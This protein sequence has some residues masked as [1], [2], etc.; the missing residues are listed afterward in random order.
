MS[1]FEDIKQGLSEAIQYEKIHKEG[2][3]QMATTKDMTLH[4]KI[5]KIADMAGVLQKSK[6]GYSYKYV[7]E[8]DIQAKVTAGL[9][10]YGIMLYNSIVPGTLKVMPI[11]YEKY[12]TKL[13]ANK[14]VNEIIVS[15]DMT[16]TWVN[17]DN[18]DEKVE[19]TWAFVGQMEDAAQ[20]MG[21]GLT[22]ANRYYLMKQLQLATTESDPDNYRSKQKEAEQYEEEEAAKEA[23]A[24]LANK[25]KEVV[26]AGVALMKAGV[27]KAEMMGVVAAYNNGNGNPS[28]IPTIEIC[29]QV[30][31]AFENMKTGKKD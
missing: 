10:K 13:K 30:L 2:K 21:A 1:V 9:Q 14:P 22:Y 4:Q 18:P 25:I 27:E 29:E 5:L 15:G 11:S 12:D 24:K 17:A 20:A 3:S 16:Y 26:D 28:A 8:E 6:S 31:A 23:A 7:P 19:T